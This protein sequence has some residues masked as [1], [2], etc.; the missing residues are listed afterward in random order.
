VEILVLQHADVEHPGSL[1]DVWAAAGHR[2]KAVELDA[3][4]AIPPLEPFDLMVVMGGPVDV[5]EEAENPWLIPEKA[6]IRH[7]VRDLARPYLGI[8]LGHQLLADALGGRVG[9]MAKS[10]VG[11]GN[12]TLTPAGQADPLLAPFAPQMTT[13]QWHGAEVQ[14]LPPDTVILAANQACPVQAIRCGDR[15]Y[16]LQF[17]CEI[18]AA[19]VADWKKIPAYAESLNQ[20][21]GAAAASQL[22]DDV[23]IKLDEF[24][25]TAK[26]IN[27]RLFAL[28]QGKR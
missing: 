16:G 15:A 2:W 5:W 13:F 4:E 8:C 28:I 22:A 26:A 11:L 18:T 25:A 17:H 23:A 9:K 10:E 12:V 27:D 14:Q 20:A 24:R 19:T 6:A 1:C 3:G 21:L 7:W